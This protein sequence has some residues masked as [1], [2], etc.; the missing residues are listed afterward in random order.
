MYNHKMI[1]LIVFLV[2]FIFDIFVYIIRYK[3]INYIACDIN[4][5]DDN[6]KRCYLKYLIEFD[7]FFIILYILLG[8]L[9]IPL[10][11][12]YIVHCI[13]INIISYCLITNIGY[14]S[15]LF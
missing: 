5:N 3:Y 9:S 14:T 4:T 13:Y 2:Y 11:N 7:R 15:P 12:H 8:I 6:I 1:N 10:A